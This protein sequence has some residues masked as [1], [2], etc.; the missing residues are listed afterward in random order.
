M[1]GLVSATA[2]LIALD[3]HDNPYFRRAHTFDS[4][5]SVMSSR[6]AIWG[7]TIFP[8][9]VYGLGLARHDSYMQK[10]VQLSAESV[11]D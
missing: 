4:F 9:S 7:M 11:F 6:S 2:G 10:T 5:N 8:A 3:P 1:L